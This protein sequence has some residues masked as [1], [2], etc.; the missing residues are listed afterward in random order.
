MEGEKSREGKGE[1]KRKKRGDTDINKFVLRK[2]MSGTVP[3]TIHRTL[4]INEFGENLYIYSLSLPEAE[5][6]T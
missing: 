2:N 5:C 4:N 1:R 3:T 6:D